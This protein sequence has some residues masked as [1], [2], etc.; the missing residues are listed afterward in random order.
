MGDEY[1]GPPATKRTDVGYKR[2][3]VEHRFKPGQKPPPR[4]PKAET[5]QNATQLL[6]KILAE[7]RR[8][9]RGDKAS[10]YSN[11]YLVIEVAFQLAE[12]E[13]ATVARAL[14]E[15][16]IASDPPT[17]CDDEPLLELDPSG[18]GGVFTQVRRYKV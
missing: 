13:N 14:T 12:K 2:P 16:L 6:A 15:Y 3:P 5:S 9:E 17:V 8:L 11:G 4:K 18:P 7:E 1:Q 10:W